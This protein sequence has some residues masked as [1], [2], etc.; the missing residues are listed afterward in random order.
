MSDQMAEINALRTIQV[1]DYEYLLRRL[2]LL[3]KHLGIKYTADPRY[4]KAEP[5]QEDEYTSETKAG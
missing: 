3:E 1:K 5:E 4:T 2:K